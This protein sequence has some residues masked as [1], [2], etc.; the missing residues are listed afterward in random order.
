MKYTF[1]KLNGRDRYFICDVCQGKYF[2]S[3]SYYINDPNSQQYGFLVCH[4]D[5][6]KVWDLRHKRVHRDLAPPDPKYVRIERTATFGTIDTAAGL[7]TGI[8]EIITTMLPGA[9]TQFFLIDATATQTSFGWQVLQVGSSSLS[10]YKIERES[11]VGNGYS[12]LTA[13][14]LD[15]SPTFI[16]TTTVSGNQY[17]Y[18]LKS[19]SVSGQSPYSTEFVVLVP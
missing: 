7:E 19:I 10:G 12:V 17:G 8:E 5:K 11:P 2:I 9:P 16:D 18:R 1:P 3:Q 15:S 4:K 13:N 6:D 14:T